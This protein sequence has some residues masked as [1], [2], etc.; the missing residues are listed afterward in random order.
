MDLKDWVDAIEEEIC[1]AL[2]CGVIVVFVSGPEWP[3]AVV[4]VFQV[5]CLSQVY[6]ARTRSYICTFNLCLFI[7]LF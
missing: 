2:Y 7:G 3:F 5:P 1:L 6:R 4:E